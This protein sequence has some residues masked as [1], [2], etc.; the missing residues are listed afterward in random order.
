M[1]TTENPAWRLRARGLQHSVGLTHV[2]VAAGAAAGL[3]LRLWVLDAEGT[4][5]ADEAVWGLMSRRMLDGE[6]P[7]F[8]WGQAYGGTQEAVLGAPLVAAFGLEPW[9]IRAVP[10]ALWALA[11]VLV[12][13]VGRHIM[14]EHAARLAAALFWV[15]PAYFIWKST[16]AHGFY[17]SVLVLGLTVLLLTLRLA[18]R[19][20]RRDLV[21]L[22]LALGCGWWASPQIVVLA[23][24]ALLWLVWERREIARAWPTVGLAA[25]A[26]A[27]PWLIANVEHGWYSLRLG[28]AQG[29]AFEHAH[30]LATATMPTAL[31]L[32]VPFSLSWVAGVHVGIALYGLALLVFWLLLLRFR[33]SRLRPLL[34]IALLFPVFYVLSP[35]TWLN[36]EPRYLATL[37]PVLAL[38]IGST[39]TTP[40][41]AVL[42]LAAALTLSIAALAEMDRH[43]L[44]AIRTEGVAVPNDIGPLLRML[45]AHGVEHAYAS[46]WVAWRITFESGERIVGA[47]SNHLRARVRGGRVDPHDEGLGRYPPYYE[48]A[49]QDPDAAH[50]F[51]AG[52][53]VEP[54][55]RPLLDRTGYRRLEA[56]GFVVFL[57]PR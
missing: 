22:G 51:L 38:L 1:R 28:D 41:R 57:A 12:W 6:F 3:G 4:L 54:K 2:L 36:T 25:A 40:R 10:L 7:V 50:V 34:L 35:Y 31:G 53:D 49:Q 20:S 56:G 13:R 5:D 27:A 32:R 45:A 55:V 37:S 47:P 30:N 39:L 29:T 52:G 42:V 44:S 14:E 46:Y 11:A 21:L 26:G 43:D 24:P 33:T 15:W 23:L 17:G 16:R 8:F 19:R 48:R 18:E 9:A